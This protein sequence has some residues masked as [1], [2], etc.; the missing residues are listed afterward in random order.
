MPPRYPSP[1]NQATQPCSCPPPGRNPGYMLPGGE[2]G[3]PRPGVA[4]LLGGAGPCVLVPLLGALAKTGPVA[5]LDL[6]A[7]STS[8]PI[9][10]PAC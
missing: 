8:P 3:A 9:T 2:C 10:A 5:R 4:G 7:T 1:D 6:H